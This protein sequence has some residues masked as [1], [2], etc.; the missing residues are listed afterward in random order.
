MTTSPKWSTPNRKT[1]LVKLFLDSGGFCI[2]G[3]KNCPTPEHHYS[4]FIESL[5]DYWKADDREQATLERKLEARALHSLGELRTPIRGRFNNISR[6]IWAD[7]QP[8]FYIEALG[9]SGI[10]LTPFAKVKMSSSFMRLYVDLADSLR[11]I[12]KNRKR[13]AIRYGKP[14]PKTIEE[15]IAERVRLAVRDYHK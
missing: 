14:L 3:H 15:S 4:E 1:N 5:I 9:M 13:K 2:Y 7:K 12:S 11:G 6:D 10:T 8:L